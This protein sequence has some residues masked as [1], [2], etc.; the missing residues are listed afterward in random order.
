MINFEN[1][2]RHLINFGLMLIITGAISSPIDAQSSLTL[3]ECYGLV[4]TNYPTLRSLDIY[5]AIEDAQ[6]RL[7]AHSRRP[8]IE[9]KGNVSLQSEA[10]SLGSDIPGSPISINLP[11]YNFRTYSEATYNLYEGGVIN[12]RKRI[13]EIQML[14]R[15]TKVMVDLYPLR[16][17]VN[18]IF[19]GVA[20]AKELLNLFDLTTDDLDLRQEFAKNAV[21]LGVLLESEVSKLEVRK[22]EIENEKRIV[23]ADILSAYATLSV[24][25]GTDIDQRTFLE[26]PES[27]EFVLTPEI[28]RPEL[29]LFSHQKASVLSQ[30][31]LIE[32]LDKP[33][34]LLYGQA[35][36]GYPNALN[37]S[38]VQFAP[39]A[40]GGI[41]F[42]Y[43]IFDKSDKEYKK[44]KIELESHLID[45]HEATFRKNIQIQAAR[46]DAEMMALKDQI[47][48]YDQIAKLQSNILKEL[49]IQ[50]ELGVITSTE[51]LIQSNAE[52]RA[53]QNL[54]VA[55]AKLDQKR[56]EY[57]T[58][59]GNQTLDSKH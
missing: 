28:R 40:L 9:L 22:L 35:G 8:I 15:K 36:F 10:I 53:R 51:Y 18:K 11:L 33:N 25:T 55:R 37:F 48:R 57:I 32:V 21:E 49:A 29:T 43:K 56:L 20:L 5:A 46:Y 38:K 26:L 2:C 45:V 54:Q 27:L 16:V 7:I 31:E 19:A 42:S 14:V 34:I 1:T 39:Y 24:L 52:L 30:K 3:E 50:M 44:Q 58:I 17:Q 41:R 13:N 12:T 6:N 47:L 4:E 59:Y 23:Q